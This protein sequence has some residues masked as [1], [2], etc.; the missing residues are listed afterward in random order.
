MLGFF[1]LKVPP[2]TGY[3]CKFSRGVQDN[4]C[5]QT[6][7]LIDPTMSVTALFQQQSGNGPS[8]A[9]LARLWR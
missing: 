3:S 4:F 5:Y 8:T 1:T 6:I 7:A 9:A 2:C